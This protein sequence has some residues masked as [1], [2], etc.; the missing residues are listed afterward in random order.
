MAYNLPY[1]ANAMDTMPH[2]FSPLIG[3]QLNPGGLPHQSTMVSPQ[4]NPLCQQGYVPPMAAIQSGNLPYDYPNIQGV[5]PSSN[6]DSTDYNSGIVT[7]N[8]LNQFPIPMSSYN[9]NSDTNVQKILSSNL[10]YDG[11]VSNAQYYESQKLS[12]VLS[13]SPKPVTPVKMPFS[14]LPYDGPPSLE[15]SMTSDAQL[16]QSNNLPYDG[17]S[18][19]PNFEA[20]ADA[21][22][23]QSKNLPYDG[24]SFSPNFAASPDAQLFQ[25]VPFETPGLDYSVSHPLE[26]FEVPISQDGTVNTLLL[27]GIEAEQRQGVRGAAAQGCGRIGHG[28]DT[29]RQHGTSSTV[30]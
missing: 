25:S 7:Q 30:S 4:T 27:S 22:L 21:Q 6:V 16:F 18:F 1:D 20:S 19:S 24:P 14:N 8:V 11:T 12:T 23:L 29:V 5:Y 15:A 28:E 17:P 13:S 3:L 26:G 10:P 9:S 2:P